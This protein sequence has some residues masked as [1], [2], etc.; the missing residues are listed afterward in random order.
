MTCEELAS[1]Y[2]ILAWCLLM[3]FPI[4]K[5]YHQLKMVKF[6]WSVFRYLL[7][8]P[9][10]VGV[11][12]PFRVSKCW[13]T[14]AVRISFCKILYKK[15]QHKATN[16]QKNTDFFYNIFKNSWFLFYLFFGKVSTIVR[17]RTMV[18]RHYLE[19]NPFLH[20]IT[21]SP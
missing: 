12:P 7:I 21:H 19:I 14:C 1:V 17:H 2:I 6:N 18:W 16:V 11:S 5:T 10:F 8:Y 15:V 3:L 4:D 20:T 13:F 9:N